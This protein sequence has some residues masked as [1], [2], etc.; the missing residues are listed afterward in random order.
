MLKRPFLAKGE[1]PSPSKAR[2]KET[3]SQD[4]NEWQTSE[5]FTAKRKKKNKKL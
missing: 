3:G 2:E 1:A 5:D 4:A